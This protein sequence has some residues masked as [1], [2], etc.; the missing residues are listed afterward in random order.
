MALRYDYRAPRLTLSDKIRLNSDNILIGNREELNR[1]LSKPTDL[2]SGAVIALE[3]MPA[4]PAR[5]EALTAGAV[6]PAHALILLSG[7]TS[8][9]LTR[10][11][12]A[13]AAQSYPFPDSAATTVTSLTLPAVER[14]MVQSGLT[15]GKTYELDSLGMATTVFR[16]ISSPAAGVDL[17]LPSD[18]YLTP[19]R[20]ASISLHM[21]YDAAMRSDSVL[22]IRL[23]AKFIA[24][25]PLD[26]SRGDYFKSYKIDIP[27]SSFLPGT[28][29][30]YFEAEMTP[31]HTDKCTLIQSENLRLIIY[32]DSTV[33]IPDVPHWIKMPRVEVFFQ[34]AFPFGSWPDLRETTVLMTEETFVTAGAAVNAIALAAQKIGYPPFSLKCDFKYDKL[35]PD[36]DVLAVGPLK[37]IPDEIGSRAPLTGI[38]PARVT[39][40]AMQ[41][42]TPLRSRPFDF[43]TLSF[44]DGP[45]PPQNRSERQ[46]F[47]PI[48]GQYS[49]I[50]GPDRAVLMQL[51]HP[52]KT[53]RTVMVLTAT[54]AVEIDKA[55]RAIWEPAVQSTI[56][57]D[58]ALLDLSVPENAATSL[59]VGPSYYL[60]SPGPAA[61]LQNLLNTHPL[62]SLAVLLVL[63]ALLCLI[64][65]R[66]LRKRKKK[67]LNAAN[68]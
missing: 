57:G 63:L 18:L 67:R 6:D 39:M 4:K 27:L 16:G 47:S 32:E 42:P 2:P 36:T 26:N 59:Q 58:L 29:R 61:G 1:L 53:D 14:Y 20:F 44:G 28:N 43:R 19:E 31:L 5:G 45:A 37:T 7:S 12:E 68:A 3:H 66:W 25:V 11:V 24:G 65:L 50:L 17:R 51:Q 21:A 41:R 34:D 52:G 35:A 33:S 56:T 40:S 10:A 13:F 62:I 55:S 64:I 30:L 9:E 48:Q 22:N 8:E 54:T 38:D 60:G 23:N 15:P 49:G 46:H